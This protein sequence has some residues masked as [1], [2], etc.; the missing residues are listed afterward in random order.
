MF[1]K[2]FRILNSKER[3]NFFYILILMIIGMILEMAGLG[4]IIPIIM[5]LLKGKESLLE[6]NL[7]SIFHEVISR[8]DQIKIIEYGIFFILF[9]YLLKYLFLLFLYFNQY[10]FTKKILKRVSTK[11][12]SDYLQRPYSAILQSD[13]SR[14][15]NSLINS[16]NNFIDQGVEA[17]M[18]IISE[19]FI[20]FG[21]ILILFY[22]NFNITLLMLILLVIPSLI[23]YYSLKNRLK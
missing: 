9:V 12:Y 22:Y 3:L 19:I 7:F 18:T 23:F 15:I 6:N 5:L 17:L 10:N 20:F 4:L 2:I 1:W 16:A 13:S 21:I 11:L 8:L 14:Q